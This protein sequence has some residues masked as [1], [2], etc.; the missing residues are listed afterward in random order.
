MWRK[1]R[2]KEK[3]QTPNSK[4]QDNSKFQISNQYVSSEITR[5]DLPEQ[6]RGPGQAG[7]AGQN[8]S[9]DFGSN[10]LRPLRDI[11]LKLFG[12]G[13]E[14]TNAFGKLLRSHR[15]FIQQPAEFFLIEL[16]S[17]ELAIT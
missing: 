6:G 17:L 7:A 12:I 11:L 8:A 4:S 10:N 16:Q 13:V 1:R 15:I 14:Q 5:Y 3:F 2:S 9:T